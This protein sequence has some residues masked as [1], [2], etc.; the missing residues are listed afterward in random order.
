MMSH[1]DLHTDDRF[2]KLPAFKLSSA[3]TRILTLQNRS[4]NS[5]RRLSES[6]RHWQRINH[7]CLSGREHFKLN[8]QVDLNQT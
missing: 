6:R 5:I 8:L 7:L 1:T 3:P 4:A 2:I